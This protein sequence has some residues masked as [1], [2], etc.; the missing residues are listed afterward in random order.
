MMLGV[1]YGKIRYSCLFLPLKRLQNTKKKY[2]CQA[3]EKGKKSKMLLCA[4]VC[5]M[6]IPV[7]GMHENRL[8]RKAD[9][10]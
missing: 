1:L 8:Y 6:G 2:S 4:N 3:D 9:V 10:F 5:D 7:A